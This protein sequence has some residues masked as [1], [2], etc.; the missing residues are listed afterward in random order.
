M[1]VPY[2][3]TLLRPETLT[4]EAFSR[5]QPCEPLP[6]QQSEA[7]GVSQRSEAQRRD[8][9]R[10]SPGWQVRRKPPPEGINA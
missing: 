6:L 5:P 2:Y 7:P 9:S 8:C 4:A 1:R 10:M 3:G